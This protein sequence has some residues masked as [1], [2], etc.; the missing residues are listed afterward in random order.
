MKIVTEYAHEVG[1]GDY[2]EALEKEYLLS[3]PETA[4]DQTLVFHTRT[5]NI[6]PLDD[7]LRIVEKYKRDP[8]SGM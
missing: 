5:K 8:V 7:F 1:L 3:S 4:F 2:G 6:I